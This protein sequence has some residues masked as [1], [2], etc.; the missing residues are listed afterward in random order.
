MVIGSLT[1]KNQ[2]VVYLNQMIMPSPYAVFV[3]FKP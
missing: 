3:F 2:T 1:N